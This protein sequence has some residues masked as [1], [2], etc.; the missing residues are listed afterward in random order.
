[1][2]PPPGPRLRR[3]SPRSTHAAAGE[4]A[5]PQAQAATRCPGRR[6][7]PR[8]SLAEAAGSRPSLEETQDQERDLE[9]EPRGEAAA[10]SGPA[11]SQAPQRA[12]DAYR[13]REQ[14]PRPAD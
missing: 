11:R 10:A 14:A 6:G 8:E 7:L 4:R 9:Q 5:A 12:P 13:R 1:M 3:S 2:P